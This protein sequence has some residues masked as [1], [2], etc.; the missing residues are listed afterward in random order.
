MREICKWFHK[1]AEIVSD[2]CKEQLLKKAK[3]KKAQSIKDLFQRTLLWKHQNSK[4]SHTRKSS[5]TL[6]KVKEGPKRHQHIWDLLNTFPAV[7][8][9]I[10]SLRLEIVFSVPPPLCHH[11]FC[12]QLYSSLFYFAA[13]TNF[14]FGF[15]LFM[16][17]PSFL[18]FYPSTF[19]I[20][21]F[22]I[23]TIYL[24]SR[25]SIISSFVL[26]FHILVL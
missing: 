22:S 15:T 25:S 4:P 24:W 11:L 12:L 13:I 7:Q 21:L 17:F 8:L 3:V 26:L 14:P 23:L 1:I 19:C 16:Q 20:S 5:R 18:Y 2:G 9:P 10:T 6:F